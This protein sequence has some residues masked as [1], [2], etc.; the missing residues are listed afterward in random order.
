MPVLF[1]GCPSFLPSLPI[2]VMY[3][4]GCL[5]YLSEDAGS[6]TAMISRCVLRRTIATSTVPIVGFS[7]SIIDLVAT[8]RLTYSHWRRLG[9]DLSKIL[10]ARGLDNRR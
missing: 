2:C 3:Y 8:Y 10:G 6:I 4:I 1:G 9:V 7:N 5:A